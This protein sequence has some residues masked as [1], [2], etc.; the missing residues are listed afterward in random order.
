MAV[1]VAA[2]VGRGGETDRGEVAEAVAVAEA[3]LLAALSRAD[4]ERVA[5]LLR[6]LSLGFDHGLDKA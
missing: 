2:G 5:T 4:R 1:E 6:K 3:E